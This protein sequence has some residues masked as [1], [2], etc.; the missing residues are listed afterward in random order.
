MCSSSEK[1][2]CCRTEQKQTQIANQI[3]MWGDGLPPVRRFQYSLSAPWLRDLAVSPTSK[4]LAGLPPP[5]KFFALLPE[6]AVVNNIC[7]STAAAEAAKWFSC[8]TGPS[9]SGCRV[10]YYNPRALEDSKGCQE[11]FGNQWLCVPGRACQGCGDG[12]AD[13]AEPRGLL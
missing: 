4:K 13:G 1:K 7:S 6:W 10:R 8:F 9:I 11:P 2:W 12:I 3:V 5:L